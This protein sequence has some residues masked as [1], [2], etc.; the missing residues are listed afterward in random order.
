MVIVS[1][2]IDSWDVGQ[3]AMDDGGGAFISL[4]V[5]YILKDL[6]LRPR[7]TL[8]SILWTG[9][10]LAYKGSQA[11]ALTHHDELENFNIVIESDEG[12]FD[13]EGFS[14]TGTLEAACIMQE[15]LKLSA[16]INA[17]N[18]Y[19]PDD[20]SDTTVFSPLGVPVASLVVYGDTYYNYHHSH[21][22]TMTVENS[23]SLD[24]C[25]TFYAVTSY[26]LADLSVSLP[27]VNSTNEV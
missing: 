6:G 8:R 9:E 10:E 16:S 13:P 20:G 23:D 24:L 3:G 4:M 26:V 14:F 1:G 17:S 11:Y 7:R 15:V 25:V 2:H 18:L 5:P 19:I 27:R 12:T 22:D 21:G